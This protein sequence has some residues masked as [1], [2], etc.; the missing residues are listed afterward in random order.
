MFPYR[1]LH[2]NI[3]RGQRPPLTAFPHHV[4]FP[5]HGARQSGARPLQSPGG[6]SAD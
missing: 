4:R 3:T 5:L 1:T 2:E 6:E